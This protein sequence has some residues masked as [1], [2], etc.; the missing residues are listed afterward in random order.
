[1]SR[2]S[3]FNVMTISFDQRSKEMVI[4]LNI[5]QH[6]LVEILLEIISDISHCYF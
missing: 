2:G 5:D 6:L 1:M 3:I 4:T